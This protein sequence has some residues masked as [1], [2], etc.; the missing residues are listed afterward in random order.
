MT[1]L[2]KLM[3]WFSCLFFGAM[4]IG[5]FASIYGALTLSVD[6]LYGGAC[7]LGIFLVGGILWLIMEKS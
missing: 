2:E 5:I 6:F 3:L 4:A 7:A 1:K